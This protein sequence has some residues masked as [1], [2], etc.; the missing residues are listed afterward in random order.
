MSSQHELLRVLAGM[1]AQNCTLLDPTREDKGT[2]FSG[3]IGIHAEAMRV[4]A[5][6]GWME[7]NDC[8]GRVVS[9]KITRELW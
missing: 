6:N 7:I 3:F 2:L 1:V 8:G 5:E 4:L 9:G